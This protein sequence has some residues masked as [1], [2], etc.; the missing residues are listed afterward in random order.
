LR[1]GTG[2]ITTGLEPITTHIQGLIRILNIKTGGAYRVGCGINQFAAAIAVLINGFKQFALA[3]NQ[4]DLS[5]AIQNEP[6]IG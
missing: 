2:F 3:L 1:G 5:T 4:S 6:T